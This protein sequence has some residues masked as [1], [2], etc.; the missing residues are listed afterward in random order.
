MQDPASFTGTP[1]KVIALHLNYPSR[2]AQ[3]G[4]VP[5]QPS[6]FLKPGTS[7]SASGTPMSNRAPARN[8]RAHSRSVSEISS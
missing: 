1:G 7:V 2:I 3:R 4:R 6:Y 8:T 5:E